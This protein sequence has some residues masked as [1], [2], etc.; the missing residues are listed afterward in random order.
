MLLACCVGAPP[1]A[2]ALKGIPAESIESVEVITTPPARYD[3]EGTAGTINIVLKKGVNQS[4]N[5]RLGAGA[6]NRNSSVDASLNF[7]QGK[8]GFTSSGGAGAWY[9][10]GADNRSRTGFDA[11]T[12]T[13]SQLEQRST[14]QNNGNWVYG[15]AGLDFDPAPRHSLSLAGSLNGY[16]GTTDQELSNQPRLLRPAQSQQFARSTLNRFSALNGDLIGTYTRTFAQA[17]R[18]WSLLGQAATNGGASGYDFDQFAGTLVPLESGQASIRERARNNAPSREYTA[19]TD[20]VQPFGEKQTLEVGLKGIWRRN[21]SVAD[22]DTDT[23]ALGRGFVRSPG[24][25]TDF[26]CDQDVQSANATYGFAPGQKTAA[27]LGGRV[28]RTTLA[29]EFR[30]AAADGFGRSYVTPLPNASVQYKFSEATSLRGA[31]SRR[32]TRPNIY[33][34]QERLDLTVN[35]ISPF[36]NTWA[37]RGTVN[38]PTFY[39]QGEYIAFQRAWRVYVGYRFGKDGGNG[40]QRKSIRNDDLKSGGSKQG[41]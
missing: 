25:A 27:S 39:E 23:T 32:I 11:A 9:N 34:L 29:A 35:I 13:T 12:G 18:E 38:T 36:N 17:R 41:G 6:G 5:G 3:G 21:A 37:Y 31:Y 24:R 30:A 40:R 10:P 16:R 14:M 15:S 1:A 8:V 22:I 26:T 20:F 28:E 7:R 2:Q 33:Y 19:Q 4:A